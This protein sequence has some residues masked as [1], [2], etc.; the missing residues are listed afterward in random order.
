[1]ENLTIVASTASH[2]LGGVQGYF[3]LWLRRRISG[4]NR[5]RLTALKKPQHNPQ[6]RQQP[7]HYVH[8][9]LGEGE[10]GLPRHGCSQTLCTIP[11]PIGLQQRI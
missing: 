4:L 5:D 10:G 8:C 11:E 9:Q 7:N 3:P 1:M 6:L 2:R